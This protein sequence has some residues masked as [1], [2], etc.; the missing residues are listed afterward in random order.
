VPTTGWGSGQ[1]LA[2]FTAAI[3]ADPTYAQAY[4]NRAVLSEEMGDRE[5]ALA[6]YARVLE[7]TPDDVNAYHNHGRVL[8]EQGDW[9]GAIAD[10]LE[11]LRRAPDDART[12]NNL[13]WLW[14][15]ATDPSHRDPARAVEHATRACELTGWSDPLILDTLA[16]ACAAAGRYGEAVRHQRQALELAPE[17]YHGEMRARLEQYEKEE[18]EFNHESHE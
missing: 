5:G 14:A 16:T 18:E 8:A 7:L 11:A 4:H 10:H 2:D 1:A 3:E 17:G 6:D 15:S 12:W 13:A 9:S